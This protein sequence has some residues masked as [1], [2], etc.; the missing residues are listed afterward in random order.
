MEKVMMLLVLV[1]LQS[2]E[3]Q[4]MAFGFMVCTKMYYPS[5][6]RNLFSTNVSTAK[7]MKVIYDNDI[8]KVPDQASNDILAKGVK[9]KSDVCVILFKV[10]VPKS[11]NTVD[12]DFKTLHESLGHINKATVKQMKLG[13]VKGVTVSNAKDYFREDCQYRKKHRN[14]NKVSKHTKLYSI[15]E[16]LH[17]DLC[18][19]MSVSLVGNRT[20]CL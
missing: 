13:A 16:C 5:F 19:P 3:K 11:I 9:N 6:G 2:K 20:L 18:G 12:T 14:P 15:C 17:M 10:I 4:A 7:G 1:Q 8:V